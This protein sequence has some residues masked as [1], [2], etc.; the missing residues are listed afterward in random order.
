MHATGQV[1][2]ALVPATWSAKSL[3]RALNALL[4]DDIWVEDAEEV[5]LSFHA[6][7]DAVARCYR[8]RVG[9]EELA[10]SPFHRH[11]CWPLARPLDLPSM[12]TAA[13]L[14][15]G[16]HSFL[17]FAKAGQPERGDRCTVTRASW[18]RWP[19]LGL[20]FRITANRF[21]HHMVRY[22][23]GTMVDIGRERRPGTDMAA[24]LAGTENVEASPPAPAQGLSL[25]AVA[26]DMNHTLNED[27]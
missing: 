22:L 6:R 24:L 15:L 10:C 1:A 12:N 4:P 18:T 20:E 11:W 17:C 16:E 27:Q 2:S 7:Y 3:R 8:Y 13:E 14:I 21:L 5:P 19:D 26:Y 23:V 25:V 9:T